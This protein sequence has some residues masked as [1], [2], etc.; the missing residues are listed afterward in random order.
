MDAKKRTLA[1]AIWW[2]E[3][4]KPRKDKR[5]KNSYCLPIEVTNCDYKIIKLF[6]DFLREDIGIPNK[7]LKGQVQIHENDDQK[8]IEKYWSEKIGIPLSQFNKTIVRKVGHK[9]GKNFGT[10]KLRT[11]GKTVYHK[12]S[13]LLEKELA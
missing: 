9:P 11:Y 1:L 5:W 8:A 2:C 12:L 7:N 4:T 13:E 3:G 6:T 10:F